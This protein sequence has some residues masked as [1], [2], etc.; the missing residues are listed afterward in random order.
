MSELQVLELESSFSEVVEV[1]R[2]VAE[3]RGIIVRVVPGPAGEVEE[4]VLVDELE[5]V[6]VVPQN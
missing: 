3:K 2:K 4:V 6:Q 1:E 5:S